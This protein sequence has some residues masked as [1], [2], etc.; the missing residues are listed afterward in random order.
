MWRWNAS[1]APPVAA[2]AAVG[3]EIRE[4]A[5]QKTLPQKSQASFASAQSGVQRCAVHSHVPLPLALLGRVQQA[6]HYVSVSRCVVRPQT[7][8]GG[9]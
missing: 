8:L 4:R 7:V 2:S 3:L 6:Q 1:C 5:K 9:A